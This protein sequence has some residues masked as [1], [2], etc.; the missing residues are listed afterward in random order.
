MDLDNFAVH[1]GLGAILEE[2]RRPFD[3]FRV[4]RDDRTHPTINKGKGFA[5]FGGEGPAFDLFEEPFDRRGAFGTP[6]KGPLPVTT[7]H[8]RHIAGR[9]AFVL[10]RLPRVG[11]EQFIDGEP[12]ILRDGFVDL[13][14]F[15]QIRAVDDPFA[16]FIDRA[17][18]AQPD[19]LE[20]FAPGAATPWCRR[21]NA[22]RSGFGLFGNLTTDRIEIFPS[23]WLFGG[24]ARRFQHIFAIVE[25]ESA[26]AGQTDQLV[27]KVGEALKYL[28]ILRPILPILQMGLQVSQVT[29]GYK[30]S[31]QFWAGAK[32][33]GQGAG[34]G[35][36]GQLGLDVIV[37]G[38]AN[39]TVD[40]IRLPTLFHR[41][42]KAGDQDLFGAIF[43]LAVGGQVA[44]FNQFPGGGGGTFTAAGGR[45]CRGSRTGGQRPADTGQRT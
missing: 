10:D 25:R 27:T 29:G 34:R 37:G 5:I 32:D 11:G 24:N 17:V 3:R 2:F 38:W 26:A 28:G 44:Q 30:V 13:E 35:I 9:E 33:V 7:G 41:L 43:Q 15:E 23:S 39:D 36:Q 12:A 18:E 40:A 42:V 8:N 45:W 21:G 16:I 20:G 14:G 19:H 6:V 31:Q 1:F 22:G 4:G